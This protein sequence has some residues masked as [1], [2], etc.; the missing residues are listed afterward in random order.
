MWLGS[1]MSLELSHGMELMQDPFYCN[2]QGTVGTE[3]TLTKT[4]YVPGMCYI[5]FNP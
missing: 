2:P 4:I 5:L 1:F 3:L